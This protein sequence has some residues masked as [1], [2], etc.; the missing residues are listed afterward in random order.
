MPVRATVVREGMYRTASLVLVVFRG[1]DTREDGA[2]EKG[3]FSL[4]CDRRG[5]CYFC[6]CEMSSQQ[7]EEYEI[8]AAE[9]SRG[10]LRG[11]GGCHYEK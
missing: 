2:K 1:L 7:V 6:I 8:D 4:F 3:K 9:G 10:G 11:F 5:R